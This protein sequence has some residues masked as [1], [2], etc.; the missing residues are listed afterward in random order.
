MLVLLVSLVTGTAT[1]ASAGIG[2]KIYRDH[3]KIQARELSEELNVSDWVDGLSA[4]E[5]S[6]AYVADAGV[7]I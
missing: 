1:L 2:Y 5:Q 7:Q 4:D 3:K 6:F